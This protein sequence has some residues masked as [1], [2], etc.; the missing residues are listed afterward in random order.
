MNQRTG[1]KGALLD[2]YSKAISE[3]RTMISDISPS[4]LISIVD[5]NT[6][7]PNCKSIQTILAHVVNSGY[8]YSNYVRKNQNVP[9]ELWDKTLEGDVEEYMADL[10]EMF[11]YSIETF[12]SFSEDELNDPAPK[13][14]ILTSWGSS[15]D[16]EQLWEHAIV[17]ILRHRRQ[18]DRFKKQ[19]RQL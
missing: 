19:L 7:D 2:E 9:L 8:S 11:T 13:K 5:E 1:A 14:R 10:S 15:Y 4:E 16:L 3:L 6:S 18:I 12:N 17:H